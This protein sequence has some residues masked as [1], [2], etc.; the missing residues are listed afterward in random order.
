M[1]PALFPG[2]I[3]I[4]RRVRRIPVVGRVVVVNHQGLEKVK[5]LSEIKD[6]TIYVTGDNAK[7]SLDSRQFGYLPVE[8]VEAVVIWPRLKAAVLG[9]DAP[10]PVSPKDHTDNQRNR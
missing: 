10:E 9:F 3:I 5:R 7:R 4:A 2:Q 1:I 8:A 6:N